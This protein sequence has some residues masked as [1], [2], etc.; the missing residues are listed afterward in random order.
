MPTY[1]YVCSNCGRTSEI[2]HS[3]NGSPPAA[4]PACGAVGTLR[5]AFNP[6]TIHFKGSGWAKKDRSSGHSR[7]ARA[8]SASTNG[9]GSGSDGLSESN[10]GHDGDGGGD[11]RSE[12]A[13]TKGAS[14]KDA[15]DRS[16]S[17]KGSSD[18]ASS[19]KGSSDK[20]S[21]KTDRSRQGSPAA[22]SSNSEAD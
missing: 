18:K 12:P 7:P 6:P 1:D 16:I 13:P 8:E 4:C 10:H 19:D 22:S 20:E 15:S 14:N 9:S 11:S 21:S 2:V 3:I 17:D 5:K